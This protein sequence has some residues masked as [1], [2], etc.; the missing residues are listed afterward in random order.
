MFRGSDYKIFDTVTIIYQHFGING[1]FKCHVRVSVHFHSGYSKSC[2]F[3]IS[4]RQVE[5]DT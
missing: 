4:A 2:L 1:V 3:A 5:N